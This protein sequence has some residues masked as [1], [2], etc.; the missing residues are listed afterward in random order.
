MLRLFLLLSI[1]F[2]TVLPGIGQVPPSEN[3]IVIVLDGMRWQEVFAGADSA[4][5]DN[6]SFTQNKKRVRSRFWDVDP[7][8]RREK[9]FPFLWQTIAPS[10]QLYGN[11]WQQSNVNVQNPYHLTY[12]GFSEML[13]GY[14]NPE[15]STN[16]L[17]INKSNNVLEMVNREKGFEGKVALFAS[18]DLFPFLLDKKRAR[19]T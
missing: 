5:I 12:P 7:K 13:T 3:L 6:P 8:I 4:L 9:L 19:C 16:K 15:I 2:F 14:V 17:V 1:A 10:G 11:R 18:S